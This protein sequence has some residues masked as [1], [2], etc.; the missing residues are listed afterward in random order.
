ML[1]AVE[2]QTINAAKVCRWIR[3]T[4]DHANISAFIGHVGVVIFVTAVHL[5]AAPVE[6]G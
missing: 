2:T 1:A 5:L 6:V 4:A 3:V